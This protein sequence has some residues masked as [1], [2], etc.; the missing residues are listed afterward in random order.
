MNIAE[1]Q[2]VALELFFSATDE[3]VEEK[4]DGQPVI[5]KDI[6]REGEFATTPGRKT[7][8]PMKITLD[9]ESSIEDNKISMTD[10]IESFDER[11]FDDVTIPDGHPKADRKLSDG[12][13]IQGD[14][15][16]NN[17]GYVR[18][19][20]VVKKKGKHFLQGALG[21]TE[22]DVA[23]KVR[24]GTV[25]NVSS[26]IF[27]NF[28]RKNDRRKFRA[29][30]NHVAL[31]KTPWI[32]DLDPF[33]KVFASD[34]IELSKGQDFEVI[35]L[36]FADGD[37]SDDNS[38]KTAEIVWT[39]E[40]SA[41]WVREAL[42]AALNPSQDR[43][44]DS[45]VAAVPR[46]SYYVTDVSIEAPRVALVE[47]WYKGNTTNFIVPFTVKDGEVAPAPQTRWVES[48]QAYIAA[49]DDNDGDEKNTFGELSSGKLR[50]K[51]SVALSDMIG[52]EAN[53]L[54]VDE[55]SLDRR[56][57]IRNSRTGGVYLSQFY[58]ADDG[59]VL[60]AIPDNWEQVIAPTKADASRPA[61]APA[62][63]LNLSTPEGRVQAARQRRRLLL[64]S[65]NH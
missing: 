65:S 7:V 35:G 12:T 14:S 4:L 23:S 34:E 39:E 40:Q 36:D 6:L 37:N 55:V 33:K 31:T 44:G 19:L 1:G 53:N 60:L 62:T 17:T 46:A 21:F 51:L 8:Q 24:R 27:L 15:A 61:P 54:S 50:E 64:S 47:E 22:P 29:A 20:R 26:G 49:S 63:A 32:N 11:A 57:M 16:L 45:P 13:V 2:P 9:G 5:W 43:Y 59:A 38:A 58:V 18:A 52:D 30:L 3:G 42:R 28:V 56:A 10:L 41:N 48:K 25:P